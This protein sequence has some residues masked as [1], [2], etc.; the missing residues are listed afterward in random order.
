[1]FK[2][3]KLNACSIIGAPPAER[4]VE[5][6]PSGLDAG[7]V[8]RVLSL[9]VDGRALSVEAGEGF[10]AVNGRVNFRLVWQ[11][12]DGKPR[13]ADY[14]ADF[15]LRA[16]GGFS[17][18]DSV[19]AEVSVTEADVRTGDKVVL[20][21]L[22]SVRTE[23]MH[24]TEEEAEAGEIDS[25]LLA[26]ARATAVSATA[27]DGVVTV[28][29]RV[30]A[31]VTFLSDGEIASR[32]MLIP[33]KEEVSAEGVQAGDA[34]CAGAALGST[35]IVLA[36]VPGAE[37]IR[38]EGEVSLKV[39][40]V[41]LVERDII[42]DMFMLTN[43]VDL[44]RETRKYTYCGGMTY[45]SEAVSGTASLEGR[46]AAE[47]V[48]A[49]PFSRCLAAKA[50]VTDDG[51]LVEGV[52]V[53]DIVYRGA[54][55]IESVRAEVPYSVEIDGDFGAGV[56]ASCFVENIRAKARRGELDVEADVGV[57]LRSERCCEAE[58]V[59]S[60]EVGEEKERN[61]SALSLYIVAEGDEMWDVCKALTA[62]PDD[63][64]AQNPALSLPLSPGDRV[65]YFRA[66][67]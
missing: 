29:G 49:V 1:M 39:Q 44:V 3:D 5:F 63:I 50:E 10:A 19:T 14:N 12:R 58:F 22:I 48:I 57:L 35:R 17:P 9:A 23:A 53:A 2:Y 56:S 21:A 20:T 4:V 67:G 64:M 45:S 33:F 62:T 25:V 46:A 37:V 30:R 7:D 27:G 15:N 11:D 36:G 43:E 16:E 34:V 66:L 38:F 47:S 41:R 40:A 60:V 13:G 65:V 28:E 32:E 6:S 55:G 26:D 51:A 52:L 24:R 31:A 54:D 61:D 18:E 8:A 59:S 42:A